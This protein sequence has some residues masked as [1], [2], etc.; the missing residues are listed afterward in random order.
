MKQLNN[1]IGTLQRI[2]ITILDEAIE[3]L[4]AEEKNVYETLIMN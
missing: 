1:L 3:H 4:Q 2:Q